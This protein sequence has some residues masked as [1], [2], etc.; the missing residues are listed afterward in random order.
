VELPF[1]KKQMKNVLIMYGFII[2]L[3]IGFYFANQM[4]AGPKEE[5]ERKTFE[6]NASLVTPAATE[7]DA[8]VQTSEGDSRFK[9]LEK[10]Y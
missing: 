9:L 6:T 5:I 10:G 3:M 7:E 2:A 1:S 8:T 4:L